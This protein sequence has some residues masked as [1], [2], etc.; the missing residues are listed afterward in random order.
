MKD[1][2]TCGRLEVLPA[3]HPAGINMSATNISTLWDALWTKDWP[4]SYAKHR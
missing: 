3:I 1:S 4:R 2:M